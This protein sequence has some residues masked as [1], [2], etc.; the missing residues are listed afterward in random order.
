[1]SGLIA[2]GRRWITLRRYRG[3]VLVAACFLLVLATWFLISGV[4][5]FSG[6][7]R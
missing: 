1:V 3:M 6:L 2:A 4:T 5:A 7:R